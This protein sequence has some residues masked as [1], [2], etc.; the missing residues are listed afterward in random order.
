MDTS[1]NNIITTVEKQIIGFYGDSETLANSAFDLS[2]AKDALETISAQ[3]LSE[4][5]LAGKNETE[6]SRHAIIILSN[7]ADYCESRH[8]LRQC[9]RDFDIAKA[10]V[11]V[12]QYNIALYKALLEV[13]HNE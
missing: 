12:R 9:Q 8:N 2:L 6:R 1:I 13:N 11:K 5:F 10:Q 4:S 7:D 3:I